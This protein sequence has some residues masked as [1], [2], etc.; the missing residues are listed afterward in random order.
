MAQKKYSSEEE[1]RKARNEASRKSRAK[2]KAAQE[3]KKAAEKEEKMKAPVMQIE[4]QPKAIT[5]I[6]G[7]KLIPVKKLTVELFER[8]K[9]GPNWKRTW[10][11]AKG[12]KYTVMMIHCGVNQARLRF[13]K[14]DE[15]VMRPAYNMSDIMSTKD[16]LARFVKK[17]KN[18]IQR[19]ERENDDE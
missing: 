2:K 12:N 15:V 18:V 1:R 13:E 14:S 7:V 5:E 17:C 3:A 11:S 10:H 6:D 8:E 16:C 4:R 19:V 9:R